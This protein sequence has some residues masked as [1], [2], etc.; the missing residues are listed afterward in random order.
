M[1]K[2]PPI[3]WLRAP[4]VKNNWGEQGFAINGGGDGWSKVK[5]DNHDIACYGE[6]AIAAG[7]ITCQRKG[8]NVHAGWYLRTTKLRSGG[9]VRICLLFLA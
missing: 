4:G 6:V 5:F 3:R 2:A 1:D 7:T 9:K 8:Q